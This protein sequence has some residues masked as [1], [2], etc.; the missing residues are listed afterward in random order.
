[1]GYVV[2]T[3][4]FALSAQQKA[5][6]KDLGLSEAFMRLLLGR[7][8]KE[9][10]I[11][12]FLHPSLNQ[13]S[14]PFEIPNMSK[15]VE[16]IKRAVALGERILIFGDYD[17]DGI[18]AVSILMLYL[19]DKACVSYF[20]PDRKRNGYGIS[21]SA[22]ERV[23]SAQNP[24]LIITVDCGITAV[25]EAEYL[26][27]RG[28]DLIV[29]DHHE[30]QES[31]PDCI[32]VDPKTEKKG[33]YEYCGA[34]VALMLIEALSDREEAQKYLD[35]AAIATI[36]DVVPLVSDNRIIAYHGLKAL[37]DRPR[38][39]VKML[40]GED[41]AT[42]HGIMFRLAPRI[43]AAGRLNSA[44]KAVD[45][46]LEDDYFLLKSLTDELMRD[47]ADRQELCEKTVREAKEMLRGQDF[48]KLG[49][50]TL[51]NEDWESGVV[52]IAASKL[53]EEFRRP[54]VL[55][56]KSGDLLKGSA[57]S[58]PSVNIFELLSSLSDYFTSFGGH[59]QAAGVSLDIKDFE[60]FKEAANAKML[61][62]H[63]ITEFMPPVVCEQKLSL[64][65]D[66][67]S[68][69]KELELLEPTGCANPKPNFLIEAQGLKFE[70][71]GFSNHMKCAAK[72]LDLIGFSS[73]SDSL[74]AAIDK[75]NL[76][77]SLDINCFRNT[78]TAQG[79][80][81]SVGFDSV[82]LSDDEAKC[83]NLHHLDYVGDTDIEVVE[84]ADIA[85]KLKRPIGTAVVCFSQS[86]Y[87]AA[88]EL[89][90]DI[91]NMP[92]V[93]GC[94][95][96]L[97]PI[98]RVIICPNA[99]L[100]YAYYSDVIIAGSPL[101]SGYLEHVSRSS[102]SCAA[103][104][105]CTPKRMRVSDDTLRAIYKAVAQVAASKTKISNMRGLYLQICA[106]Y[107]TDEPTFMLAMK[108]FAQLGL[109]AVG[110]RGSVE[111]SRKS[112]KLADSPAYN[113]ILHE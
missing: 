56:S 8:M 46:F 27:G 80:L 38:K 86:E 2:K 63:A 107:K 81:R 6:A 13:L 59:A 41:K 32:I 53:A 4:D 57:R 89:S 111:V 90:E 104:A 66:F 68:F 108:I 96:E 16:R 76:E 50:I 60:S 30:P 39:G 70:N 77:V 84:L 97:N 34:G 51:Y 103:I 78:L 98:S 20:I 79:I 11:K 22:L 24:K 5:L 61:S 12:G 99:E 75:I 42:A 71:I 100:E 21:V 82:A 67:L 17:C 37:G 83:L 74:Y 62:E 36:A 33:F 28:I 64:D 72:N 26:K 109:V 110:A 25:K 88:C 54:T 106:R 69:A 14:S 40:L 94:P 23:I 101:T 3:P 43:N 49:I 7:G 9:S 113:Q 31:L 10:D 105:D 102:Q 58:I 1:M 52:G 44:M 45:L 18:C 85:D 92:V 29:T 65:F 19:R 48:C 35:I 93:I 95:Q 15:A 73:F 47:N 55:F 112:V 87:E 91:R